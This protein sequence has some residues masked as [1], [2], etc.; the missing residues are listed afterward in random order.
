MLVKMIFKL[1]EL[2]DCEIVTDMD[3]GNPDN[4]FLDGVEITHDAALV[5]VIMRLIGPELY[6]K[7]LMS[8]TAI[9][10][11]LVDDSDAYKRSRDLRLER[12]I[13]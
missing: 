13:A 3:H 9:R 4:V 5:D 6:Q 10:S 12:E 1:G 11:T 2:G 8:A 7:R